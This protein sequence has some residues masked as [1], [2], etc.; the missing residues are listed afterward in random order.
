MIIKNYDD[1][2]DMQERDTLDFP[3]ICPICGAELSPDNNIEQD[4]DGRD[5]IKCFNK[6]CRFKKIIKPINDLTSIMDIEDFDFE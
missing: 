4:S 1:N 3:Y 6:G 2:E 5:Y